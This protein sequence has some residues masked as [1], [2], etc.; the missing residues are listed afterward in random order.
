MTPLLNKYHLDTVRYPNPLTVNYLFS[1]FLS[2]KFFFLWIRIHLRSIYGKRW[3]C[4]LSY[5]INRFLFIFFPL[6]C[7]CWRKWPFVL[8]SVWLSGFCWLHYQIM[9]QYVLCFLIIGS[10]LETWSDISSKTYK[11]YLVLWISCPS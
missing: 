2:F 5:L 8:R 7:I 1:F 10:L 11:S 6:Q 9:I 3:P 4:F